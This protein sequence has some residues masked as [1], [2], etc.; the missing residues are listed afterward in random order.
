M[1]KDLIY[2]NTLSPLT[3]FTYQYRIC[4]RSRPFFIRRRMLSVIEKNYESVLNSSNDFLKNFFYPFPDK[5]FNGSELCSGQCT[6][7]MPEQQPE[8]SP[9]ILDRG[10]SKHLPICFQCPL[11]PESNSHNFPAIR[12]RGKLGTFRHRPLKSLLII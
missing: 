7:P 10:S 3:S 2:D 5:R 9:V 6:C 11:T 4:N 1:N 12:T 8:V